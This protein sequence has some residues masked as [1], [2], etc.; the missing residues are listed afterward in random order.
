MTKEEYL[1][2]VEK[3]QKK[4]VVLEILL[5]AVYIFLVFF[6]GILFSGTGVGVWVY[7]IYTIEIVSCC[8]LLAYHESKLRKR[9]RRLQQ[10]PAM[11][12]IPE[13]EKGNRLL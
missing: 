3:E 9:Y 7:L 11:S 6:T 2:K 12:A 5:V 1:Q 10:D 4:A 8:S 13:N